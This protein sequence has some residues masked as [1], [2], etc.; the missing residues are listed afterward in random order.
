MSPVV[1]WIVAILVI[2]F[3]LIVFIVS[4]I[5]YKKTPPPKGCEGMEPSDEK[6]H[7][8]EQEGCHFNLYYNKTS[9]KCTEK[10]NSD[11]TEEN[12]KENK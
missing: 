2:L 9:M 5:L 12:E 7:G 4:F 11:K 8:C 10:K 6:C 1:N 3:F